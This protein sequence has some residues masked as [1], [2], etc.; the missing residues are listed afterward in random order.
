MK[1][2]AY[3]AVEKW[4]FD[5][6]ELQ[7]GI[8]EAKGGG[9]ISRNPENV[10]CQRSITELAIATFPGTLAGMCNTRFLWN[11]SHVRRAEWRAL[12]KTA[13]KQP[14]KSSWMIEPW[15]GERIFGTW[16]NRMHCYPTIGCI[17]CFQEEDCGTSLGVMTEEGSFVFEP[18]CF[19]P[20]VFFSVEWMFLSTSVNI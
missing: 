11:E 12:H 13:E 8:K 7:N 15:P 18:M 10:E 9:C 5:A 20:A 3:P 19:S 1:S 6:K 17:R 4:S 14:E 16:L 2:T